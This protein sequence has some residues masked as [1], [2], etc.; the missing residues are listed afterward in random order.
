MMSGPLSRRA[1]AGAI[2]GVVGSVVGFLFVFTDI[3]VGGASFD[4]LLTT[5]YVPIVAADII[6]SVILI[7]IL[8]YAWEP[9][10]DQLGR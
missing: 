10:K 1:I 3:W 2:A 5:G 8:V 7:P 4:S 6:V 9:V